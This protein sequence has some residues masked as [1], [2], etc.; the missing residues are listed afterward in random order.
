MQDE[1][2]GGLGLRADRVS[3][4]ESARLQR[5][6]V[7]ELTLT[8][9]GPPDGGGRAVPEVLARLGQAIGPFRD[10][11]CELRLRYRREDAEVQLRCG[12]DWRVRP[13][14]TL[15]RQCQRLLGTDAVRLRFREM[16]MP[17]ESRPVDLVQSG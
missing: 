5:A 14:D 16:P 6:A 15:L 9:D 3:R 10:G 17:S 8:Q 11:D 1:Y 4:L 13:T 12:D 7:L 2:R